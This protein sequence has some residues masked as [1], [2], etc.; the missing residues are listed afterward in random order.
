MSLI[1]LLS[2]HNVFIFLNHYK[3]H[4]RKYKNNSVTKVQSI[5]L[6]FSMSLNEVPYQV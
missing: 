5:Q 3:S 2:D 1:A 4:I 6:T